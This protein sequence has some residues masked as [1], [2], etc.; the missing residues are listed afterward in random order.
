[1]FHQGWGAYFMEYNE[2]KIALPVCLTK[3]S[4]VYLSKKMLQDFS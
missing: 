3:Y 2:G 4:L 1:M